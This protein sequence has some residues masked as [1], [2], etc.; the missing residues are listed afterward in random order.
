[1]DGGTPST[2]IVH[3]FGNTLTVIWIEISQRLCEA[4]TTCLKQRACFL[5][6]LHLA[7]GRLY[8][9]GFLFARLLF[10]GSF[11]V[12]PADGILVVV[13]AL[14]GLTRKSSVAALHTAVLFGGHCEG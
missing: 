9:V 13:F 6:E 14:I 12:G 7:L 1:M 4:D 2:M 5:D 8:M 10:A 11:A 3:C